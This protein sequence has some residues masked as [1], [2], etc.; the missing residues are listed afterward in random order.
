MLGIISASVTGGLSIIIFCLL[1]WLC[2]KKCGAR[3]RKNGW[4]LIAV[5]L[6]IPLD[7]I[8]LPYMHMRTVQLPN[9]VISRTPESAQD[10]ETITAQS[11]QK[12]GIAD[13]I[14]EKAWQADI[15]TE[16]ILFPIWLM[17][18]LI[19]S[20]YHLILYRKMHHRVKRA[21]RVCDDEALLKVAAEIAGDLG[22]K[23]LPTM[24]MIESSGSFTM[25]IIKNTIYLPDG[26]LPEKDAYYIIKHELIHC[27]EHDILCKLLLLAV[28]IIH[29]FNPLVWLM[30]KLADNDI[31]Q[32][33][34]EYVLIN[35]S[36]QER[37]EYAGVIMSRVEQGG[38]LQS[39]VSTGYMS[40]MT[41]LKLR[42]ANIF[43]IGI[44]RGGEMMIG[45]LC[46][47][48]LLAGGAVNIVKSETVYRKGSVPIDYG[49]E[50]RADLNGDGKEDRVRV[51]YVQRGDTECIQIVANVNGKD[52][53]VKEYS[54]Y[55]AELMTGDLS[56]DGKAD[57]LVQRGVF[58][59][60]YGAVDISVLH[61]E[62]NEWLEY[63]FDF[64]YNPNI[65]I[66]QPNTFDPAKSWYNG[67]SYIGATIFERNGKTM[68][69]F[70]E[71][72]SEYD[73]KETVKVIEASYRSRGCWDG[74]WYGGWY[75]ED[76]RI[77]KDFYS[78]SRID[79]LL[80]P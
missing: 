76:V 70:I 43:D 3:S 15:S 18:A 39:P 6:L 67:Y 30:R 50:P 55:G 7:F 8:K 51:E 78:G 38:M 24:H 22:M 21:S 73:N 80:K 37:G 9:I 52:A 58:G 11:E 14:K 2:R 36:K 79:K 32:A 48:I 66:E 19:L 64:I 62:D 34:D 77:V 33:C 27:M 74:V 23:K 35:A 10:A 54:N 12:A 44:K 53:A 49:I 1:S 4:I 71:L 20:V 40:E 63:P 28:N 41:F 16:K 5:C 69:R 13:I 61:L 25:G 59:S 26:G 72:L 56:G 68:V 47:L 46:I 29:W 31:E 17:G 57:V 45:A 42:V 65:S 60:N 75:I